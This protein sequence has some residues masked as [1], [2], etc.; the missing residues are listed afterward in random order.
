M[1][2][3]KNGNMKA[4]SYTLIILMIFG[5]YN[6]ANSQKSQTRP[7]VKSIVV[8]EEKFNTLIKRQ[9]KESETFYDAT[10]NLMEEIT[11]KE[12]KMNKHFKYQYD[13]E[14]NK[15]REEEYDPS[16]KL[17]EFSVYK[18]ENG[19]RTEKIVYD[20]NNSLKSKKTYTYTIY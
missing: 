5:I 12:G 2:H 6:P 14:S 4:V 3:L 17:I 19:L 7:K 11:Y 15:T 1:R 20:G 9:Y 16:G 8:S 13:N 18:I 10:G